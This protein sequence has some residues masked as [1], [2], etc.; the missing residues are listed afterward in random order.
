MPNRSYVSAAKSAKRTYCRSWRA[1]DWHSRFSFPS[2]E[3]R[4]VYLIQAAPAHF[5]LGCLLFSLS[6]FFPPYGLVPTTPTHCGLSSHL[7]VSLSRPPSSSLLEASNMVRG[8]VL[9][10]GRR[11]KVKHH[12]AQSPILCAL[13]AALKFPP[14][15]EKKQNRPTASDPTKTA[16]CE[17]RQEAAKGKRFSGQ[18]HH[19]TIC[20]ARC[21]FRHSYCRS[22]A[23]LFF[24][25]P[26]P[27]SSWGGWGISPCQWSRPQGLRG[28]LKATTALTQTVKQACYNTSP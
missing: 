2:S 3:T 8:S 10:K 28:M 6:V 22:S 9:S 25:R 4:N 5:P 14:P 7:F 24:S 26:F 11:K 17:Q 16:D 19:N 15:P 18:A 1:A 20:A 27:S 12:Q 13:K 23:Q 21:T